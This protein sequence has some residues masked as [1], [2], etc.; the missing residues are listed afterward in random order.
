M[1]TGAAADGWAAT[2]AQ[3]APIGPATG[4]LRAE[5]RRRP[6]RR[7]AP[8]SSAPRPPPAP[9]ARRAPRG[10]DAAAPPQ[11]RVRVE[12]DQ[13]PRPARPA[14]SRTRPPCRWPTAPTSRPAGAGHQARAEPRGEGEARRDAQRRANRAASPFSAAPASQTVKDDAAVMRRKGPGPRAR[15]HVPPGAVGLSSSRGCAG[16]ACGAL[17]RRVMVP[18][19]G[20]EDR[21]WTD[22][23]R[24][25]SH[26]SSSRNVTSPSWPSDAER[27]SRLRQ[28]AVGPRADRVDHVGILERRR[29]ADRPSIEFQAHRSARRPAPGPRA[30]LPVIAH[31]Q[32]QRRTF[33]RDDG[34][35]RVP[36]PCLGRLSS[37]PRPN[38]YRVSKD[39]SQLDRRRASGGLVVVVC[40]RV[41]S[42]N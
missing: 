26:S 31:R 39:E 13:S 7:T 28:R 27:R 17:S 8:W 16:P 2:G 6:R 40:S 29:A 1:K 19:R 18:A 32:A 30:A 38:F 3:A 14:G 24:A 33:E 20:S 23:A 22:A 35:P 11:H 25:L 37:G 9:S 34:L 10:T 41:R 5:R 42:A 36:F 21:A 12:H 15:Q 4:Q